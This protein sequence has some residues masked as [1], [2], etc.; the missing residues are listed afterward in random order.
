MKAY[1]SIN[2]KK[3]VNNLSN[4]LGGKLFCREERQFAVFLY[5]VFWS[6]RNIQINTADEP[7]VK[8]CLKIHD[9]SEIIINNVFFEATLMRDYFEE[10]RKNNKRDCVE[11][12]ETDSFNEK[13]LDFCLEWLAT[14]NRLKKEQR[15]SVKEFKQELIKEMQDNPRNLGQKTAEEAMPSGFNNFPKELADAIKKVIKNNGKHSSIDKETILKAKMKACVDIARMMMN[16]TPDI[17]VIYTKDEKKYAK[18]LECKY[19]S[20]EGTYKDVAGVECKM[21][22]FIQECVMHFLFGRREKFDESSEEYYPKRPDKGNVWGDGSEDVKKELW[23]DIFL[24]VYEHLL[25]Q[26]SKHQGVIN[27]GV[28]I[29]RFLSQKNSS[30]KLNESDIPIKIQGELIN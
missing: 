14:D 18:A 25:Q 22:R 20:D 10:D 6:K 5:N 23:N 21:Q 12:E 24:D 9:D 7:I 28:E 13:L 8:R 19:L 15:E 11:K 27:A 16:A 3:D 1:L 29:V 30:K 17:M 2:D 4:Y 26:E